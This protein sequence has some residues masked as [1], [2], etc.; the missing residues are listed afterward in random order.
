MNAAAI[1]IIAI[2]ATGV[3]MMRF[4][5]RWLA[6]INI[7]V[8]RLAKREGD[9]EL[10]C[11]LWKEALGNSRHGYEAYEQAIPEVVE[12]PS[13]EGV[14]P[15]PKLHRL[16]RRATVASRQAAVAPL[17]DN[18]SDEVERGMLFGPKGR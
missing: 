7:A 15:F 8:A 3:L 12:I 4:R 9:F 13:R 17:D 1:T 14:V 5:K 16:R 10:A 11:E 18:E 2:A 6:K